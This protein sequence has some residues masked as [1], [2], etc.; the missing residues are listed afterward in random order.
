MREVRLIDLFVPWGMAWNLDR[1]INGLKLVTQACYRIEPT[2]FLFCLA[3]RPTLVSRER[4]PCIKPPVWAT[5]VTGYTSVSLPNRYRTWLFL[6]TQIAITHLMGTV[7]F[8]HSYLLELAFPPST[9][10]TLLE[11]S[12]FSEVLLQKFKAQLYLIYC[13]YSLLPVV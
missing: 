5:R 11:G 6:Q 4:L 3:E 1:I 7:A 13:S 10:R 8:S 9:L 12:Y 2:L